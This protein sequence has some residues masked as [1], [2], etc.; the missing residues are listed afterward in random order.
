MEGQRLRQTRI[1]EKVVEELKEDIAK[2]KT[3]ATITWTFTVG[4]AE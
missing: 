3:V 2:D 1:Y 4:E